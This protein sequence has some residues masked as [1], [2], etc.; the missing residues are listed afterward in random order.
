MI[1]GKA[2]LTYN[3]DL[4]VHVLALGVALSKSFGVSPS[5][6][7][8][9]FKPRNEYLPGAIYIKALIA[10]TLSPT[11]NEIRLRRIENLEHVRAH[12]IRFPTRMEPPSDHRRG[13]HRQL[14]IRSTLLFW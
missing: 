1:V 5:L 11:S 2:L 8:R 10:L 9:Y 13:P 12:M 14:C 6:S 3:R 7:F 4:L